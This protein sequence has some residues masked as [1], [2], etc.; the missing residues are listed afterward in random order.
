VLWGRRDQ[1]YG[2]AA[3]RAYQ[4]EL[5]GAEIHVLDGGHWLLETHGPEVISLVGEFLR[6]HVAG[7]G[8]WCD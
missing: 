7:E 3:A 4:R 6:R 5:P 2:E 8:R 1:Y